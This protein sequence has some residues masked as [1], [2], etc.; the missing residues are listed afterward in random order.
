MSLQASFDTNSLTLFLIYVYPSPFALFLLQDICSVLMTNGQLQASDVRS[1]D[2]S[3]CFLPLL[4]VALPNR[5]R[6]GIL[7]GL[8]E[9]SYPSLHVDGILHKLA[10]CLP[11]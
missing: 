1:L 9:H 8:R 3:V 5:S 4:I 11:T 10:L 6:V 7:I 2:K